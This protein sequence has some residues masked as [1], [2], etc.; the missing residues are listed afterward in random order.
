MFF[1]KK[2]QIYLFIFLYKNIIQDLSYLMYWQIKLNNQYNQEINSITNI[3]T[4]VQR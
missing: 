3:I 1:V 2:L 4:F